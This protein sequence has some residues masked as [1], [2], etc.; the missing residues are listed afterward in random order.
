MIWSLCPPG[1]VWVWHAAGSRESVEV[2]GCTFSS[3]SAH[4]QH[5]L[6]G[7]CTWDTARIHFPVGG[8]DWPLDCPSPLGTQGGPEA[9]LVRSLEVLPGRGE[10][11]VAG[12][13]L[14]HCGARGTRE[15][16]RT[17]A[18]LA[19]SCWNWL[20]ARFGIFQSGGPL[21]GDPLHCPKGIW[22]LL[23]G[24]SDLS[25]AVSIPDAKNQLESLGAGDMCL[26]PER[27]HEDGA[28]GQ[29]DPRDSAGLLA[30]GRWQR[31]GW[32]C[33]SSQGVLG[34]QHDK[35]TVWRPGSGGS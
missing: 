1:N 4:P 21:I 11:G 22:E 10:Q 6:E 34:G 20:I 18:G 25:A 23:R 32:D 24:F 29:E 16:N 3:P 31:L 26:D 15:T 35:G 33:A 27:V 5:H 14:H 17:G 30:E 9:D 19:W 13:C 8:V 2:T 12:S 7:M 28:T